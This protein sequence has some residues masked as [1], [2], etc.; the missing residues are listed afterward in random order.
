[1]KVRM[2]ALFACIG[3]ISSTPTT[4]EAGFIF[5]IQQ[6][7]NNVVVTGNGSLN[8]T[9][10]EDG[11]QTGGGL[12]LGPRSAIV[13]VG[14]VNEFPAV[15][16]RYYGLVGPSNFGTGPGVEFTPN[17]GDPVALLG[18]GIPAPGQ[19][20]LPW[21]KVPVGYVSGRPLSGTATFAGSTITSLGLTPGAYDYTWGSGATADFIRVQIGSPVPV[22]EPSSI[23]MAMIGSGVVIG[24]SCS[25]RRKNQRE[26]RP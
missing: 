1:M 3:S 26:R 10:L 2:I 16:D 6:V 5:D 18:S 20:P 8:L 14:P 9:A 25:G 15:Y 19:P 23:A 17:S 4:S 13:S 7:G 24:Y 12:V 22:P 21:I 11:G